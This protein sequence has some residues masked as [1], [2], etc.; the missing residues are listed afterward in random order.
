[1]QLA[2]PWPEAVRAVPNAVLRGALFSVSSEREAFA[3]RTLI[4]SVEGIEVRFQGTRPNQ[5]DLDVWEMLLH[6]ARLQPLSSEVRFTANAMLK[7]LGRGTGKTQHEQL[8]DEMMRLLAGGVEITWT[9]DKKTFAGTLISS[10]FRDEE[11]G[12]YVVKFNR[13]FGKLYATGHTTIDWEQRKSLGRNNLAKWLHGFYSS[14]EQPY[15]YKVETIHRLC[16]SSIERLGD[17]RKAV[18]KA[19]SNITKLGVL[20]SWSIDAKTDLVSVVKSKAKQ[21]RG[22]SWA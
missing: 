18:R 4:A 7:E 15:P 10:F 5:T 14:H 19:L 20:I 13:D 3:K 2:L 6:L 11:T 16:G 22:S 17:F 12:F 1:V 8:K 21:I 9:K